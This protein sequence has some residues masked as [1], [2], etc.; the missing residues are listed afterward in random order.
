LLTDPGSLTP[1]LKRLEADDL[2]NRRRQ[3]NDERVVELHLTEKGRTLQ[4]K[5]REIPVC[6][7]N[8][9]GQ[10]MTDLM[11]LKEQ[12]IKLRGNLKTPT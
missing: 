12:L 7:V 2:L 3:T 11:A 5:A 1:L 8:A 6:I 10:S 4:D 9:S